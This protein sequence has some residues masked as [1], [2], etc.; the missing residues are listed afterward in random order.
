MKFNLP[1]SK[2]TTY[3]TFLIFSF[4]LFSCRPQ[5]IAYFKD[6]PDT[7]TNKRIQLSQFTSPV[8]QS[9]D[10][11]NIVI[12]TIDPT[13]NQILNQGNLPVASGSVAGSTSATMQA[14][15]GYL[16]NKDGYI[17]MP[18]IGNLYV[19]G[20]TTAQVTDSIAQKISVYF[21][22]PVVEVRFAN[23]KVT[24]LGEVKNPST[25]VIPN[26]KATV[27]DALGLA[28]DMT[29]YGKRENVLLM[30]DSAGKKDMV[31]LDLN[32]SKAISSPYFY[33]R[34]N[35]VIYVEASASKVLSTDAY[36]NRDI[37]IISASLSL[38]IL[39]VARV[40]FK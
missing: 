6:I 20:L 40:L 28:G 38:L 30:R 26:E 1:F 10:I 2:L 12:Q 33:L 17:S 13:T 32:N 18:Y 14:V 22:N 35:D 19:K 8:V 36:R 34:P 23:F 4:L 5:R 3:C 37:A 7:V 29:I 27:I 31:R 21:K 24:V 9:D 25:F 15:S 16:V 11:L 39:I